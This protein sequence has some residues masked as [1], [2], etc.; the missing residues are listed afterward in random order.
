MMRRKK[1]QIKIRKPVAKKP[2]QVIWSK[3][4]KQKRKRVKQRDLMEYQ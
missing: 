2:T 3:K 1:T 4:D